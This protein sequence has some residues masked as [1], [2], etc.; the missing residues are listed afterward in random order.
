MKLRFLKLIDGDGDTDY[1]RVDQIQQ[2]T[3]TPGPNGENWVYVFTNNYE[4]TL[5]LSAERLLEV[6]EA[7]VDIP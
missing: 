3:P 6:L 7:V 4:G 5:Q 2:F 1:I